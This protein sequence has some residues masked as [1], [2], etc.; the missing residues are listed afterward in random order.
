MLRTRKAAAQHPCRHPAGPTRA[1]PCTRVGTANFGA[2]W[3]LPSPSQA[4]CRDGSKLR[5]EREVARPRRGSGTPSRSAAARGEHP[6]PGRKQGA[7]PAPCPRGTP[8]PPAPAPPGEQSPGEGEEFLPAPRTDARTDGRTDGRMERRPGGLWRGWGGLGAAGGRGRRGP[9]REERGRGERGGRLGKGPGGRPPGAA[10][11]APSAA[12]AGAGCALPGPAGPAHPGELS[13]PV[14]P[15]CLPAACP[16]LPSLPPGDRHRQPG[17]AAGDASPALPGGAA[18]CWW[19][20][21]CPRSPGSWGWWRDAAE[22]WLP[23]CVGGGRGWCCGGSHQG[24]Q[25][26]RG[27]HPGAPDPRSCSTGESWKGSGRMGP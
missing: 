5:A 19:S 10:G 24:P 13:P 20:R 3:E 27:T 14:L 4:A 9:G 18:P 6:R 8:P 11:L 12:A 25:G 26:A 23:G 7:A 16:A 17:R 2:C 15:L 21:G 22:S 1:S